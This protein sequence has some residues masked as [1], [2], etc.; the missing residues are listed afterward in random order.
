MTDENERPVLQA[1]LWSDDQTEIKNLVDRVARFN[2]KFN[3]NITV[4]ILPTEKGD[5]QCERP[6]AK[7]YIKFPNHEVQD[8][9]WL[10]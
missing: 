5:A 9:F 7:L 10:E 1:G 3:T 6:H 8:K 2:D 4:D